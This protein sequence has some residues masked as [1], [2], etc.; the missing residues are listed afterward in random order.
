MKTNEP[1]FIHIHEFGT[2]MVRAGKL[3]LICFPC[4][5]YKYYS[6]RGKYPGKLRVGV[7]LQ[8]ENWVSRALNTERPKRK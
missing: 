7:K 1:I 8:T 5:S 4:Q 2:N 3:S 6:K